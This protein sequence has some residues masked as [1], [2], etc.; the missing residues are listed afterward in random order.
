LLI[1]IYAGF[2]ANWLALIIGYLAF[3]FLFRY[4]RASR[5]KDILTFSIL[6]MLLVLVHVYT[7][8]LLSIGAGFFLGTMLIFNYYPRKSVALLLLVLSSSVVVDFVRGATTQGSGGIEGGMGLAEKFLVIEN[9]S[10]SWSNLTNTTQYMLGSIYG[11]FIILALA[12]YWILRSDH[13][14]PYNIFLGIFLS[15]GIVPILFGNWI[16]Q[17]RSL[18]DIP[19]QIPAAV[20]LT[21]L[22]KQNKGFLIFLFISATLVAISIRTMFNLPSQ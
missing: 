17:S 16:A 21:Y 10:D 7:W 11:N 5:K 8:S 15:I 20:A 12:F 9:F 19:F 1:G 22:T 13:R 6:I 4:L 3:V 18:Y 14:T 2:L